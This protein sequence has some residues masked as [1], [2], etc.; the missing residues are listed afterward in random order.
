[1][2]VTNANALSAE[3]VRTLILDRDNTELALID[4]RPG[5]VFGDEHLLW[6]NSVPLT[7]LEI[8]ILDRVPR[9]DTKV[10]LCA[11]DDADDSIVDRAAG[12][13]S[14]MGYTDVSYLRGGV[15]AWEAAGFEV[16]SG[17]NVPSKAFGEFVEHT[18]DTPR[19]PATELK[20]MMDEG[21]NM[22]VLDSR[23]MSEYHAMNIPM[24]VDVPGAELALRVHDLA[25][26]PET[27][28]VVNCAGRTRSI[29][30]CQ[31]L[32]NAGIPNK[33]VA[34]EN[35][36]MGWHL[37]GFDLEYGNTRKYG[38]LT[39][40]GLKKAQACAAHV[41]ERFGVKTIDAVTLAEW[42]TEKGRTTY[43]L[44]VRDPD[45]FAEGHVPGSRP[46]PGGQLVQATDRYVGTLGARIVCVDDNGV[47]AAMTASWLVQL[48][49]DA[50]VLEPGAFE[51][52]EKGAHVPPM[53]P[54]PDVPTIEA[55]ALAARMI[56]THVIDVGNSLSHRN[57]HIPGSRFAIR[58]NMPENLS[59]LSDDRPIALTSKDGIIAKFAAKDLIDGG[60]KG[61]VMVLEG[62]TEAWKE[63]GLPLKKGFENNL[64]NSDDVW[65]RPYDMDDAQEGAMKQYLSWEVNLVAQIERDGTTNFR[66]FD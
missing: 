36:T 40:E 31:S 20:R 50:V 34:L 23:P 29:I 22:V 10:V 24:G 2:T 11:L 55:T 17:V 66:V 46:A 12:K 47:R 33:V 19:I 32:K 51:M 25:P 41:C 15:K 21:E 27:T 9:L 64:D 26:D 14:G 1:M 37:A 38:E 16:F 53:P 61:E 39:G 13:M 60:F 28:V 62:G 30:G 59:S 6:A 5:G 49:W 65:Y 45:E 58:A 63:A 8:E 18:Y 54:V 48:G 56:Q 57:N 52:S 44:D 42:Q 3:D 35:G 7:T 43:L 4:V